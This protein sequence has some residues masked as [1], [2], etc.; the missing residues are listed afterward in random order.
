MV[1]EVRALDVLHDEIE[2]VP[3]AARVVDGDQ[4][5]VRDLGG[6]PALAHEP[7]AH[8]VGGGGGGHAVGA[9]QLDGDA[10]VETAVVSGPDLAHAALADDGGELVTVRYD[11]SVHRPCPRSCS[12][13]R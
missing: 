10:A 6:D 4:A 9:E 3:V 12:L 2:V 5:G 13:R 11:A 7:A 1:G 8:L